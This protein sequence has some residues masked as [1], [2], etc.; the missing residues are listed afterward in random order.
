MLKPFP[1]RIVL[2]LFGYTGYPQQGNFSDGFYTLGSR[3]RYIR[4]GWYVWLRIDRAP[5][6]TTPR[7]TNSRIPC[8]HPEKPHLLNAT[9]LDP[10]LR[11]LL[12]APYYLW[13]RGLWAWKERTT[14]SRR[15]SGGYI[16]SRA[17]WS[18]IDKET[19][20]REKGW[21]QLGEGQERGRKGLESSVRA[22]STMERLGDSEMSRPTTLNGRRMRTLP[23]L[24]RRT[25]HPGRRMLTLAIMWFN[26]GMDGFSGLSCQY[27]RA[28]R[29]WLPLSIA[30]TSLAR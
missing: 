27:P 2:K 21:Q 6:E 29:V 25:M 9:P 23:Q 28:Y 4:G 13:T 1:A 30:W 11:W 7:D 19:R 12:E 16:K 17:S 20:A 5:T 14:G 10:P 3:T 22:A 15:R 8:R 24:D 18:E 26:V